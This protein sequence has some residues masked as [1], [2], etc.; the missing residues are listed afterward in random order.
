M[1]ENNVRLDRRS[2]PLGAPKRRVTLI[3]GLPLTR[4]KRG[5]TGPDA[6]ARRMYPAPVAFRRI[7]LQR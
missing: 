3:H 5:W 6:G 2:V 4:P 7:V 1:S